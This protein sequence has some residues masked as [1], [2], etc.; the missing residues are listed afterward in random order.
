MMGVASLVPPISMNPPYWSL[1]TTRAPVFGLAS[2]DTSSSVRFRQPSGA[3]ASARCQDGLGSKAEQPD[4]VPCP[5]DEPQTV[6]D[7]PRLLFACLSVVPP[8][9]VT[10]CRSVGDCGP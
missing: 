1:S 5:L 3:L 9:A 7:Q 4:P 10:Y 8:I 6:S 2:A